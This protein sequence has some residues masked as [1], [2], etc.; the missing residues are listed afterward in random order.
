M[1]HTAESLRLCEECREGRGRVLGFEHPEYLET[2]S[3]AAGLLF[4]LGN[5]DKSRRYAV[6]ARDALMRTGCNPGLL[7]TVEK[8][9]SQLG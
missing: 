2:C 4:A 5:R 6:E 3:L 9:L 1:G 8:T 7:R